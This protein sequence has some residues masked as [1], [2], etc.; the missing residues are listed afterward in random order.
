MA[1]WRVRDFHDDDL[2]AAIR[3]WEDRAADSAAPVFGLSDLIAAVRAGAPAVVAVVG[4]DLAGSAV[5]TVS[6][7]QAWLMRTSLAPA[8]RKRGIGSVML[9]ELERRLNRSSRNSSLPPPRL[10]GLSGLVRLS[11]LT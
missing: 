2:E 4:E 11:S 5:A 8:W 1:P 7:A 6:G 3:L 10:H 9:A